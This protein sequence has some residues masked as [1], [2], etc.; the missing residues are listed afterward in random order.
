MSGLDIFRILCCIGVLN[1]HVVD[2]VII[3][4]QSAGGAGESIGGK[5]AYLLYYA[6]SFCVPGFFLL[7]GYFALGDILADIDVAR[8]RKI[9]VII[10]SCL[11]D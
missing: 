4:L 3:I 10:S 1:Y 2:D 8:L 7:A 6:S 9:P 5:L 11:L